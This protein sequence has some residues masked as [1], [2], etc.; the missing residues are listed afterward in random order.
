MSAAN[1]FRPGLYRHYKGGLY[2][3]VGLVSH[4]ETR[5]PMVLYISH[6]YGGLS[7]RPLHGWRGDPD[8][9][10]DPIPMSVTQK[11][12]TRFEWVGELPS[13]TPIVER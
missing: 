13:D 11:M 1:E 8:G 12:R 2:T 6:T 10:L 3:A 9:F 7:V 5:E 4:H